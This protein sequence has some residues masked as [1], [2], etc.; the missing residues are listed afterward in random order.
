MSYLFDELKSKDGDAKVEDKILLMGLQQAGKTAI[1]DVVFFDK[2]P[3]EVEDYMATVH[4]ERQY[5]DEEKNS[6]VIDSGGQESYWNE[7]VTHFR[8]LVFSNVKVLFWI[9]D[10]T[11]PDLFEESERRFS[12]TIRQFKKENPDGIIIVLC[13]KVD[14][15][16]PEELV[17]LLNHVADSFDE[18]KF[19]IRFEPSSIY[20]ADSLKE[21]VFAVM[22]EAKMNTKRF[23]LITNIGQK[24]EESEEFQSYVMENEEDPR[25]KQLMDFLNPK[26]QAALPTF[27]K[28]TIDFDLSEYD[29][30]EIVLIDRKTFS[31]VV[32]TSASGAVSIE[33][34]IKK[35]LMV[36]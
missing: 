10:M 29:I 33:K 13:H 1:K 15:I 12:F 26:S 14:L 8:H 16:S 25:I 34:S 32:G 27:G 23:E 20:Y 24:I 19:N 5:L 31:P 17:P 22:T 6:L 2:K 3:G 4:Y 18:D 11:R 21:L 28:I 35:R 30:V 9:I 36:A 7:A